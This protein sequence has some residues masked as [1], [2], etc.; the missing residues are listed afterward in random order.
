MATFLSIFLVV[1]VPCVGVYALL[2]R[3]L[4]RRDADQIKDRLTGKEKT[5]KALKQAQL[6]KDGPERRRLADRLLGG[7]LQAKLKEYIEQGGLSW[8]PGQ[9]VHASVF[10]ALVF[11]NV[12]LY[13][14]RNG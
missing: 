3:S 9:L 5:P 11:F 7:S 10:L 6:I 8:E 12:F 14:V 1:L 4:R 13:V 2:S